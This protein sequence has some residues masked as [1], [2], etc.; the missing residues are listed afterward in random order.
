[1]DTI[2]N[3]RGYVINKKDISAQ[4]LKACIKDLTVQPFVLQNFGEKPKKFKVFIENNKTITMPIYYGIANFGKPNKTKGVKGQKV[5]INFKG[6]LRGKQIDAYNA[7]YNGIKETGGG[8]LSVHCGFGKTVLA[9]KTICDLKAKTLV[10]VHKEFLLSQWIERITKFTDA[11]IGVIQGQKIDVEDKDIVLGMLQSISM[12]D[13]NSNLF[14]QFRMIVVDECHHISS[15]VFSQ[16]LP[17]VICKYTLGLSATPNRDD[18]LSKVFH[19]Y[20]GDM[21]FQ[22]KQEDNRTVNVK[23]YNFTSDE[24]EFCEEIIKYNKKPNS[25]KMITNL[26]NVDTRNKLLVDI[27]QNLYTT[28]N[29]RHILV[30]SGRIDH[31]RTMKESVDLLNL[32]TTGYYI[33]AMKK[34]DLKESEDKN[35]LFGSYAMA[36]EGLDIEGLNT[37]ILSSP[38]SSIEQ[39]VGR[40]LRKENHEVSPLIIDI[41]DKLSMFTNQGYKRRRF[42]KQHKYQIDVFD[43]HDNELKDN[44]LTIKDT[45]LFEQSPTEEINDDSDEIIVKEDMFM[46][47]ESESDDNSPINLV[48]SEI[49]KL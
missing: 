4:N 27:I 2:I 42:Y 1:M 9:L 38:R 11:R 34:K 6:S 26:T 49:T 33:G 29:K 22:K 48:T 17:K 43:V 45:I 44:S 32:C 41:H 10:I 35:V 46:D 16:A 12:K 37:L 31:L 23:V 28:N 15:R 21:L 25:A 13:Y 39:S 14:K 47:S 30:L 24:E 20:L 5:N 40:I 3:K 36:S 8:I 7:V 18:G 19:W